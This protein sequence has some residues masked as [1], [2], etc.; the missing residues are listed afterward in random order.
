M[1]KRLQ[2]YLDGELERSALPAEL[3]D[4]AEPWDQLDALAAQLRQE[5][6]PPW[7]ETRIM[8]Q[9]PAEV[10]QPRWRRAFDWLLMP[11]A[12]RIRP[13]SLALAG[14]AAAVALFIL[15]E[16]APQGVSLPVATPV[17]RSV[18]NVPAPVI[19]V[20]FVFADP[21]AT[22]VTIAGD[23]NDWEADA[24]PLQDTNADGV[25]TGLIA[26]RPG[27]HKYMFVVNGERWVTDPEAE[28]YVDDGFGMRNAVIAITLPGRTI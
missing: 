6:A 16:P 22:S 17:A 3:R 11:Q 26:L 7:L 5:S 19:Y 25:W 24:T 10:A 14:A 23:F 27:M 8:A 28:S 13:A 2:A 9:L 20:Q 18:A 1:D 4:E 21:S 12:V 15:K